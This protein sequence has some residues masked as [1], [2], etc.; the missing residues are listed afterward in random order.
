[1]QKRGW[2]EWAS[3][4]LT[5]LRVSGARGAP[6]PEE[7]EAPEFVYGR[8]SSAA[9]SDDDE[10]AEIGAKLHGAWLAWGG[11]VSAS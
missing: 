6:G 3:S 5:G 7:A 4:R 11:T 9:D 10:T 1:M 8:I 2:G